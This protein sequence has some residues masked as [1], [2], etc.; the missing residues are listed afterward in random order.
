MNIREQARS[1]RG[2]GLV[3]GFYLLVWLLFSS[4]KRSFAIT[5]TALCSTTTLPTYC[6]SLNGQRS[7]LLTHL[8]IYPLSNTSRMFSNSRLFRGFGHKLGCLN[9]IQYT[10]ET[11]ISH[12]GLL[13][14]LVLSIFN[15]ICYGY[16]PKLH[17][18]KNRR[19]Q[20]A[21]YLVKLGEN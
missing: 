8:S 1:Q 5:N 16:S 13:T 18:I 19:K 12:W 14:G 2:C 3:I 6:P 21:P 15:K 9:M 17:C 4:V 7:F 20:P 11:E 10:D